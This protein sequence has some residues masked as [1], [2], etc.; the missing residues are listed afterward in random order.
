MSLPIIYASVREIAEPRYFLTLFPILSLFSIYTVKEITRKFDKTKSITVI[1]GITVLSLSIVYLDYTKIDYQH[2]L[3]A[4]QI[5]LEVHKRTSIIND[6]FPEVKYAHGKDD[7]FWNLGTFPV[8]QSE[9]ELKVKAIRT[10]DMGTC[11][12][13]KPSADL[14]VCRQYDFASLNEFIDH[15]KNDGLTHIIADENSNRPEFLKDVFK[16]EEKFPYLTKIYDSSEHSYE[17]HLK[18]FRIDY[19]K[20]QSITQF[21]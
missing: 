15:G 17:Y 10:Y 7:L 19:K 14:A 11:L 1:I 20:F 9:T 2:E 21:N 8:L 13:E 16:N 3:E 12:K 18:V 6:Y 5:G 4:Y